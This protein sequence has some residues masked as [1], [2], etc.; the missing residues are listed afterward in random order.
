M[1]TSLKQLSYK[2]G[3]NVIKLTFRGGIHL[4]GR[5]DQTKDNKITSIAIPDKVFIPLVQHLGAPCTPLVQI[6]DV[7]KKGQKI[8]EGKG[9]VTATVHA[10]ISGEV[11]AIE[12]MPSPAGTYV[13]CVV[14]QN[15]GRHEWH[16]SIKPRQDVQALTREE[17]IGI[18]KEA[19]IVGLGGA[20]FPTHIKYNFP[21]EKSIK[22]VIINGI[23]CEPYLTSDYRLMLEET[24]AI[25][26]GLQYI[27]K[28]ANCSQGIIAIEDN[29]MDAYQLLKEAAADCPEIT[30][31]A[32]QE[33]YPQGSEK[34]L[35][36]ACT[37]QELPF[38]K[39]PLD[40]GVLVNNIGTAVAICQ[41]VEKGIP[42]IARVVTV[43]GDGVKQP[44]NYLVPIGTLFRDLLTN[45]GGFTGEIGKIIAG[46]PM[47]G[48]TVF[49]D[50]MPIVKGTSGI[51]VLKKAQVPQ[52][53]ER[54]CVRCTKCLAAC[55][56]KLSPTTLVNLT[57]QQKWADLE[58][59]KAMQC[60][61]CGACTFVC[62]AN[63]PIVQYIRRAKQEISAAKAK[64][65]N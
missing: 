7:V 41:A 53:I 47:M 50:L 14:I 65:T 38:G 27:L 19:G 63:I 42:L 12:K 21:A 23:E 48:K 29:K 28:M 35:I 31:V 36:Y 30:V 61:E 17:L 32:C 39:L 44:G 20:A 24:T 46:G 52:N 25:I 43:S 34:Q 2:G 10:T 64:S 3:E 40:L 9:A 54:N 51:V 18:V 57:K 37:G 33:K 58:E 59:N 5:K 1:Q 55:P 6:G 16:E 60:I 15:D 49:T 8:G 22:T 62:P 4:P 26:K 13:S 11:Q 45:C 56:L